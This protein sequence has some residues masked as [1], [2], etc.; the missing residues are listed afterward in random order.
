MRDL[1]RELHRAVT[2]FEDAPCYPTDQLVTLH[3]MNRRL[4]EGAGAE[5]EALL[6]QFGALM[7]N[8]KRKEDAPERVYL[9]P[10]GNMPVM[11]D[12]RDNS[13]GIRNHDPDFQPYLYEMLLPQSKTP[14]GAVV[15]CAGGD[16]GDCVLHEAY[17]TC[18]DLNG[19]G[20]HCLLLLNRTNLCPYSGQESGADAARAIR[21]ARAHAGRYGIRDTQVAFA[22]FSNG[23]LTG[24]ACIQYYSGDQAVQDQF[25]D[26]IPDGLDEYYGAP[27]AFLCVYGPRWAS[28][29]FDYERVKY[30]PVFFAVGRED[31]ALDNLVALLP[32]LWERGVETEVHTFAGVPHG[33]AGVRIFGNDRYSNFELWLPLADAFMQDV[34]NRSR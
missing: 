32:E 6:E 28:T 11:T 31:T 14:K 4:K 34:F 10:E 12:Y 24:E 8:M 9:W 25:P 5:E 3:G 2:F 18:L 26:Y 19:L 17:Q 15:V 29:V 30:P 20:Y 1:R 33:Q 21:Y 23:G 27:D 13:E 7:D 16:H 22:G